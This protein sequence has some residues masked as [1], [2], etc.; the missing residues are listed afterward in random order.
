[1]MRRRKQGESSL[2]HPDASGIDLGSREHWVAVP[3][4]RDAD[5]TQRFGTTTGE[6]HRLAAWLKSCAIRS[7][8]MESTGVYWVPLFEVLE[9][10]GF[11]V[12]LVS[13]TH[14]RNVPGRKS[15][16]KDCQWLQHLHAFGLLA[17]SFR[18]AADFVELRAYAR[19]RQ[20]LVE[21]A[22]REV[23][24]MQ[25]ALLL[26]N[27][28]VHHAVSDLAG[29]TGM[30]IVRDI[31]AGNTN[32]REL[33]K[34]RDPRC[35]VT[36]E[37]LEAALTGNYKTEHLFVLDQSLKLYDAFQTNIAACNDRIERKLDELTSKV[38]AATPAASQV[39]A[40]ATTTTPVAPPPKPKK[41]KAATR[42]QPLLH[43]APLL[44]AVT[45]GVDLTRIPGIGALTSLNLLAEI[46]PDV[47][48]WKTEK[49][50][51]SWLNL[52]PGVNKT[53]G[54]S[55]SGRRPK[56]KNR[57]GEL[58]RQAA[59][60][61]GKM[62]NAIGAFYR[63]IARNGNKAKAAVATARKLAVLVYRLL[64]KGQQYV[65]AGLELYER[66]YQERRIDTLRKQAKSFG[67]ALGPLPTET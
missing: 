57:A 48:A 19:H 55:L 53:G 63:R 58:L 34:H 4:D 35:H 17:G 62:A 31:V 38:D 60:S 29:S 52:A 44:A 40:D 6:L 22:V 11:D 41:R 42:N 43:V 56:A 61:V 64:S 67:F 14:L 39:D 45:K 13:A 16:V 5:H 15:D 54:R 8:A 10:A 33:A 7:V 47:S 23:Q 32:P 20:T 27:V 30:R 25:K 18:P 3:E 49:H 24:H 50:F 9:D 1:M 26:M 36:P 28:Q 59:V 2:A 21:S 66:Q 37:R 12:T 46:G 65:D 51:S